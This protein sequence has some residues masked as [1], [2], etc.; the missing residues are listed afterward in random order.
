M[1]TPTPTRKSTTSIRK[2][3]R[4]TFT[5]LSLAP[6]NGHNDDAAA[7][8][9]NRDGA[10]GAV[11]FS[12]ED[13]P[14]GGGAYA[15]G[16]QPS[17]GGALNG[18]GWGC[19]AGESGGNANNGYSPF[20]PTIGFQTAT[21]ANATNTGAAGANNGTTNTVSPF[22][23]KNYQSQQQQLN[24][25]AA[26]TN[27]VPSPP[28]AVTTHRFNA[29][30]NTNSHLQ[31]NDALMLSQTSTTSS[32]TF[33][34]NNATDSSS[35]LMDL[36]SNHSGFERDFRSTANSNTTNPNFSFSFHMNSDGQSSE[37]M[38]SPMRCYHYCLSPPP[39]RARLD[40]GRRQEEGGAAVAMQQPMPTCKTILPSDITTSGDNGCCCHVCGA[41][42][43]GGGNVNT[44][45]YAVSNPRPDA[46]SEV[47]A[48][49]V[50]NNNDINAQPCSKTRKSK[51]QSLLSFFPRSA[52][53]NKKQSAVES[54]A[55]MMMSQTSIETTNNAGTS[56]SINPPTNTT[57]NAT[58]NNIISCRYCDKPTCIQSCSRQ[59]E[60]CSNRFC[61][62][63]SK[64]DY[65][66][67]VERIVCFECEELLVGE[68]V[69]MMDM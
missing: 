49:A 52:T 42:P 9:S 67:V 7:L 18:A 4:P 32:L 68:D 59:C 21:L 46:A 26:N 15:E 3:S 28:D 2:R 57:T 56:S 27:N 34:S 63:C 19:C 64:V 69:D 36:E 8:S 6:L 41:P 38:D 14:V 25:T 53:S 40:Y 11:E 12:M 39:K 43:L 66:E 44:T 47:N 22:F 51:S 48:F 35:V 65:G 5:S 17:W 37:S 1:F 54:I 30:N 20:S 23:D 16:T 29:Q 58:N 50:H 10:G 24:A 60:Q 13:N 55:P 62:F 31:Q 33:A 45:M 61:T